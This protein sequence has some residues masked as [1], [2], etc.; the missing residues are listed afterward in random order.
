[1]SALTF[2]KGEDTVFVQNRGCH[3]QRGL[4]VSEVS[5]NQVT[6]LLL[7]WKCGDQNSLQVL[8]PLVYK[9]LRRLAQRHLRGER[10]GHTLQSTALVHE[11]YLR[12]VKPG[13]LRIES[14]GHF[15]A[16]ASQLMRE[17]LLDYARSRSAAKRDAGR[18]LTLDEA[19]ELSTTK[20]VDLLALDDALNQLSEMNPR[21]SRIVELRFFGGLSIEETSEFLGVSSATVEREWA[22][23]RAWLYR[24]ISRT[25][26]HDP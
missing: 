14:R 9:E 7:K 15:F 16:L 2:S 23:A 8:L 3:P 5:P 26:R 22:V 10:V 13:S 6:E 12:L 20:G 19:A 18:R 4:R 21:Q 17:I 25:E 24:Q 11:A 1:V